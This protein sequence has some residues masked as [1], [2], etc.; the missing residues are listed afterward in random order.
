MQSSLQPASSLTPA[1][2]SDLKKPRQRG[3]LLYQAMTIAAMVIVL[4]TIW[5][6]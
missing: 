6:F 5:V 3:E 2:G 4:V 1:E